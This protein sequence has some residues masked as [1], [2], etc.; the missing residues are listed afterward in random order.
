MRILIIANGELTTRMDA[1]P[2]DHAFDRIIAVDGGHHHCQRL[3]LVPDIL[4][5]DL[6]SLTEDDLESPQLSETTIIPYPPAKDEIDLE[7]ALMHAVDIGAK[8]IT[9]LAALGG[10]IDMT[11]ANLGLLIHPRLTNVQIDFWHNGQRIWLIRPPGSEIKGKEG[12]T[13]SLLPFYGEARGIQTSNLRYPLLNEDLPVGPA[14]GLSNV[15]DADSAHIALKSGALL[16]IWTQ[17]RA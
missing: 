16:A 14:R 2:F 5:G 15:L 1:P 4:I 9:V 11:L 12:D 3:D 13:L 10:R 8:E 17:G 7:L 6:D